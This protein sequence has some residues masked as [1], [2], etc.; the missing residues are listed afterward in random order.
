MNNATKLKLPQSFDRMEIEG[1]VVWLPRP[2][3]IPNGSI[4]RRD[5]LLE[6][7]LPAMIGFGGSRLNV[8]LVGPPGTGKNTLVYAICRELK[9]DLYVLDGHSELTP[10]E[11]TC[12]A[13]VTSGH[14][15][16]YVASP[17]FAAMLRGGVCLFDEMG[18]VPWSALGPLASVLDDRRSI[19]AWLPGISFDA[20]PDFHFCA[21]LN[22]HEEIP[23]S[24]EE[25]TRPEIRVGYPERQVMQAILRSQLTHAE[26]VWFEAFQLEAGDQMSPRVAITALNYAWRLAHFRGQ[27]GVMVDS[28]REYIR[29]AMQCARDKLAETSS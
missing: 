22:E 2:T 20:H 17:L 13:A 1:K 29:R 7:V 10:L 26:D 21:A 8:R 16:E 12:M 3:P 5:D 11:V 18:K 25:R 27:T 9:C 19:H 14:A 24:I 28:A 23:D 6:Q 4:V 15:V